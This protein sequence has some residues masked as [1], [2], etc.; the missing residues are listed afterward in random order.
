LFSDYWLFFLFPL[1]YAITAVLIASAIGFC[2][3]A[4]F[5]R[6]LSPFANISPLLDR[7]GVQRARF[8]FFS[9]QQRF[10]PPACQGCA[11]TFLLGVRAP[12]GPRDSPVFSF[13][14]FC[15]TFSPGA[16]PHSL[17]ISVKLFFSNRGFLLFCLVPFSPRSFSFYLFLSFPVFLDAPFLLFS[18]FFP[19]L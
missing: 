7:F 5:S 13:P 18:F 10:L 19:F 17:L 9:P 14:F 11:W 4:R 3:A 12:L 1:A 15:E 2:F 8:F 16:S 6:L